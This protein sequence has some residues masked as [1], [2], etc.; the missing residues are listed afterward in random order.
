MHRLHVDHT[1]KIDQTVEVLHRTC[2]QYSFRTIDCCHFSQYKLQAT[3]W[4]NMD[5]KYLVAEAA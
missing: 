2:M 4:V 1:S 5:D 3:Y